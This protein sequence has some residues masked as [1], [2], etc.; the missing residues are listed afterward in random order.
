MIS[1]IKPFS[2][3]SSSIKKLFLLN[4]YY[5]NANF[6]NSFSPKWYKFFLVFIEFLKSGLPNTK[7][8]L[9]LWRI[10]QRS[11]ET[12]ALKRKSKT[13]LNVKIFTTK[14][15]QAIPDSYVNLVLIIRNQFQRIR[16]RIIVPWNWVFSI[17]TRKAFY[18]KI[19]A[20]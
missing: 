3:S 14:A 10:S 18:G 16:W 7:L 6:S 20:W 4:Y 15:K 19:R 1:K 5:F 2:F 17:E 13:L 11:F 8:R 9:S 12:I